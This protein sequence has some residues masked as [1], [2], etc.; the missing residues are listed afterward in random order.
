MNFDKSPNDKGFRRQGFARASQE[1][2]NKFPNEA[3]G[4]IIRGLIRDYDWSKRFHHPPPRFFIQRTTGVK[5]SFVR[6][7]TGSQLFICRILI[8][9]SD[10][11]ETYFLNIPL[12]P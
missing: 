7:L 11:H 5:I 6:I 8:S 12:P 3:G 4:D 2:M 9:F 10:F 1:W